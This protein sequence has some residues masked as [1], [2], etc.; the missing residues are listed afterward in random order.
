MDRRTHESVAE[1]Q[2]RDEAIRSCLLVVLADGHISETEIEALFRVASDLFG[3]PIDREELGRLAS[4]AT[5]NGVKATNYVL[6]I[7]RRWNQAQKRRALQG[8]FLAASVEGE[9]GKMQTE[10]L[11][12]MRELLDMTDLEYQSAIEETL[13]W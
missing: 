10:M 11:A 5:E 9:L 4:I 1:E 7:S 3:R 12:K 8:M 13:E 2:F 6:T